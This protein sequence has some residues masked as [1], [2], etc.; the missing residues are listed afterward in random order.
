M[1]IAHVYPD[2]SWH[3]PSAD[4]FVTKLAPLELSLVVVDHKVGGLARKVLQDFLLVSHTVVT[5]VVLWHTIVDRLLK[6]A[7]SGVY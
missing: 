5:D 4:S 6:V 1:R 7:R 3:G 2:F